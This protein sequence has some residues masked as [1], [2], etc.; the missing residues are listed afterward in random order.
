VAAPFTSCSWHPPTLRTGGDFEN[1]VILAS[2]V[3]DSTD[4]VVVSYDADV[5]QQRLH[6][7][8]SATDIGLIDPVSSMAFDD[9]TGLV[10]LKSGPVVCA[11]DLSDVRCT[12]T[13]KTG[14][15]RSLHSAM[16]FWGGSLTV[17][18]GAT[19]TSWNP[20]LLADAGDVR[21][22]LPIAPI[23]SLATVGDAI[24][25]ASTEHHAAHVYAPNGAPVS[26]ATGHAAGLTA[27]ARYTATEFLS[28]S[29]DQTAKLWDIRQG[30]PV[31]NFRKHNG[32]VTAIFGAP[33]TNLVVTGGT[34]RVVRGW[35]LRGTG[36]HLFA[37]PVGGSA[38]QT[39]HYGI[40]QQMLTVVVSDAV[41]DAFYD[42]QRFGTVGEHEGSPY[43][44]TAGI[45]AFHLPLPT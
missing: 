25:V 4:T 7:A 41:A 24:V 35:D 13:I 45:L 2:L 44:P 5:E 20:H 12:R 37:V 17:A 14:N 21:L 22:T 29:A 10:W 27:L 11:F 15:K 28:G 43:P 18:S 32:I 39:L 3:L 8:G 1:S 31:V 9:G 19:V 33:A 34:D 16:V 23:T 26:R 6:F 38:P 40:Q 36:R 30:I 42:L